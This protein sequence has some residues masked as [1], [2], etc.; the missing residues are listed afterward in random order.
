MPSGSNVAARA[1]DATETIGAADSLETTLAHQCWLVGGVR[2][3]LAR[4]RTSIG[5]QKRP[6]SA[7]IECQLIRK[8]NRHDCLGELA[9]LLAIPR[10]AQVDHASALH[11]WLGIWIC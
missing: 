7:L 1:I 9:F 4:M 5:I 8:A 2:W 6:Q 11:F 3:R 10:D